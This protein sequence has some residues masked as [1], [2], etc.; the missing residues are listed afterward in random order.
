MNKIKI[1][2]GMELQKGAFGGGNQFG[3]S[4]AN[5]LA[6]KGVEVVFDLKDEDIDIILLTETRKYLKSCSFDTIDVAK[7]LLKNP[8]TLVVFRV[9]ECDE[10]KGQ[11]LKLLNRLI[12]QGTKTADHV[13]F[14]SEWLKEVYT[15]RDQ[16]LLKKSSIIHNGAD[17]TIFNPDGDKKWNK[18]EP[19]RIVT[20]HWGGHW[21]KGFDVYLEL[22]TLIGKKYNGRIEFTFIGSILKDIKFKNTTVTPPKSDKELAQAIKKNHVYLTASI[23]EPAGM[24]HIEGALCGLPLLYRN[25]GALPE[26]CKNFGVSFS[27][28]VDFEKSL[29]RLIKEY[30]YWSEQMQYYGNTSEK[31]CQNYYA[32]FGNLIEE[33]RNIISKR[34]LNRIALYKYIVSIKVMVEMTRIK[35]KLYTLYKYVITKA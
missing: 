16:S 5:F 15:K 27:D 1:A 18:K 24:H 11:R 17:V 14:I 23:N 13:I 7:Y 2:L 34:N 25:S 28:Q 31:M 22:D 30:D 26:Y 12:V 33:K 6:C 10:R 19:L 8:D 35:E 29:S 9:N 20:H 3:N 21:F 32:L 4:L